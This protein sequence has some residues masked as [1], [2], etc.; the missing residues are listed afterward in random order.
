MSTTI[1]QKV[2]EMRFDNRNFENNVKQSLSTLDRLKQKL[3]LSGASKGLE[4]ISTTANKMNLN[5]MTNAIE[6]VRSKFSVLEVAGITAIANITNS[7]VNAGKRLVKSL[8]I[9]QVAAGWNKYEKKTSS[10]QTLMNSTGKS[11]DE[12][13]EYLDQLMW[14]SDETSYGFTDMTAALAQMTSSGGKIE[15]LIPMIT[16]VANATAYAGKGAAE[17]SRVMYNLN[18]SYGF[19][20]LQLMDWK[21]IELAGAGSKQ[22]KQILIDTAVELGK[23]KEG[24][25]TIASFAT[26]LKDKWADTEV[27]EQAF[28]KFSTLSEAAYKAVASGEYDTASEAIEALSEKYAGVGV[29]AFRSAQ[30][31]KTFR[32]AIDATK[33]AMGSSFMRI[34]ESIF[35]NYV[36]AKELWT[37]LANTLYDVFVEPINSIQSKIE[38][39][40]SFNPFDAL[41]EKI[42]N[43]NVGQIAKKVDNISKSLEYYQDMVNDVWRGDYKNQPY[44]KG[45]LEAEG[46]NYE[47][48]QSLVNKGYQ[49]KLT[50]DDITEAEKKH[51]IEARNTTDALENLSD[52]KLKEIGLT[53]DEIKMYRDLEAQ[54]KKTGKSI[55]ELISE[56]ENK[57][58]RTLL[59]EGFKNLGSSILKI[60]ESIKTAWSDVFPSKSVVQIYNIIAAFNKFSETIKSGVLRN[61][62]NLMRT[63]RGVF[64]ILGFISDIA[65]GAFKIVFAVLKEVLKAFGFGVEN[66]LDFTAVLG[67]A[68]YNARKWVKENSLLAKGIQFVAKYIK[69]AIE[70]TV[71]WVK[72]NDKIQNSI[73]NIKNKLMTFGNAIG[74]W[75]QGLKETDNIPKYIIDGLVNGLKNGVKIAVDAIVNLGKMLLEGIKKVLGIHS[76]STEFFEIGKNIVLGL[77]NGIKSMV[78]IAYEL[79]TTVGEK[80]IDIIKKLDIGSVF[81]IALGTGLIASMLTIS[82]AINAVTSP[83]ESLNGAIQAAKLKFTA[84]LIKSFAIAITVLAAAIG[85]LST[86]DQ[87]KL[88]SAVG[89]IT[90]LM[91]LLSGLVIAIG[92]YGS[93]LDLSA[94]DFGKIALTLLSFGIAI[95]LMA[96]A[97]KN[98][99]SIESGAGKAIVSLIGMI[100]GLVILM[101]AASGNG[102]QTEKAASM[103]IGIGVALWIMARVVKTLGKM[104]TSELEQGTKFILYFSGIIA[105]LMLLSNLMSKTDG[106]GSSILKISVALLILALLA[107]I[108]G[109][110]DPEVLSKGLMFITMFGVLIAALMFITRLASGNST[111]LEKIG[112]AI[113][114]ISLAMVVMAAAVGILGKMNTTTLG[115]GVVSVGL[116]GA[117]IIALMGFTRLASGKE[118]VDKIGT[119]ILKLSFAIGVLAAAVVILGMI[120]GGTLAKGL[121]V[122]SVLSIIVGALTYITKHAQNCMGTLIA[123]T[124]AIAILATAVGVLSLIEPNRLISASVALGLV[125]GMFAVLMKSTSNINKSIPMLMALSAA[126]VILAGALFLIGQLPY[127]RAIGSS[128][129]LSIL[130]LTLTGSLAIISGMGKLS[131]DA[132][133][134]L[135]GMLALV[136]LVYLVVGALAIMGNIQNGAQ[137]AAALGQFMGVLALVLLISAGV[138]AIYMATAGIAATGLL[139]LVVII[140]AVYAVIELLDM[141]NAVPNA[142]ENLEALTSFL[143]LMGDILL[144]LA[145]VGP[146]ALIGVGAMQ[147][148]V[149][150]MVEIGLLATA[151]G[152]LMEKFPALEDF[153]DTGMSVLTQLAEGIGEM[154]GSFVSG[155]LTTISESLPAVAEDLS[156]FMDKLEGFIQGAKKIDKDMING[157][158]YLTEAIVMLTAAKLLDGITSFIMG[159]KNFT[160]FGEEIS[161]F[162]KSLKE[163]NDTTKDIKSDHIIKIAKITD[164]FVNILNDMPLSDG[165]LQ[166]VIGE[167]SLTKLADGLSEL[168]EEYVALSKDSEGIDFDRVTKVLDVSKKITEV[169]NEIPAT[170]GYLQKVMGENSL[171]TLTIGLSKLGKKMKELS[172]NTE[173][174]DIERVTKVLDASKKITE[175]LNEIPATDGLLQRVVGEKSLTTLTDGLKE[176]GTKLKELSDDTDGI[177]IN[178]VESIANVGKKIAQA[179]EEVPPTDGYLQKITGEK[180]LNAITDGLGSLGG[181]LKKL[182]ED[183]EGADTERVTDMVEATKTIAESLN[184]LPDVKGKKLEERIDAFADG[185]DYLGENLAGFFEYIKDTKFDKAEEATKAIKT[186]S[187][188]VANLPD[189]KGK[190]IEE[191]M[192]AFAGNMSLLGKELDGFFYHI[193]DTKFDNATTATDAITKIV[194][195][196]QKIPDMKAKKLTERINT[197]ASGISIIGKEL[198]GFFYHIKETNFDNATVALKTVTDIGNVVKDLPENVVGKCTGLGNGISSLGTQLKAFMDSIKEV[199][200]A[201]AA[202]AVQLIKDIHG[203]IVDICSGGTDINSIS[204][205]AES[206]G[207]LGTKFKAF[208]KKVNKIDYEKLSAAIKSM[209]DTFTELNGL[210]SVDGAVSIIDS[211]SE[212]I[213]KLTEVPTNTT[214]NFVAALKAMGEK[215]KDGLMQGFADLET[216]MADK[217]KAG[218]EKFGKSINNNQSIAT[219]AVKTMS[220][221]CIKS[222]SIG[223]YETLGKNVVQ[224]F[225]RGIS[226]NT[227]LATAKARAMANKAEQAA[228]EA[229]DIHSPSKVFRKIGSR[230]PEGFAQGIGTMNSSIKRA[231]VNMSNSTVDTTKNILSRIIDTIDM[232]FDSQPTIRPVLDLS[233]VESGAGYLSS[234]F[235]D[236]PS[237]GVMANLNAIKTDMNNKLQNDS[238]N[239]VVTAIDKLRKDMSNMNGDTY[240]I[241]GI[242]YDD[243]SNISEAVGTLIRAAIIER[244]T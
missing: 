10:V 228:K 23:I 124:A 76:P 220:N 190:K 128:V 30:E 223:S 43:S 29:A 36:Q 161:E 20:S 184:L 129:A 137:N 72:N 146:L 110:M 147:G 115:K 109:K 121:A 233:E 206:I 62:D 57:D 134:G 70:W 116:L 99:A 50:V 156:E 162:G 18:Q 243:G 60:F 186:I 222:I 100:G 151:I 101:K 227:F 226:A 238:N 54:S 6:T 8:S 88:W 141:M 160:D 219:N 173:G 21:S 200:F 166:T 83:F 52:A 132:F 27:M 61:S 165:Y 104:K 144:M 211:F 9:D 40:M 199:E 210:E 153:L 202:P 96:K 34:F 71:N 221:A 79:L 194:E 42:E 15:K 77:F 22:L 139:G 32:E 231:V 25:V 69:M 4:N 39:V 113:F 145:I 12:I 65:G 126:V 140:G 178:R 55:S 16:G 213:N 212:S 182:S 155:A 73:E 170:D 214:P 80:L 224:G 163:F 195:A 183:T 107:R 164:E 143:E 103:L 188:T 138:G 98:I 180:G 171:T 97:L 131:K 33:D 68:I 91:L 225:A 179:L 56:M 229:L 169:L 84:E 215:G 5:G 112:G 158:I 2:V 53:D 93:K 196:V 24:E 154:L 3:N 46:H 87:L 189:E 85:I 232:D 38:K 234:L 114:K 242:T 185:I 175:L 177:D 11:L 78:N 117:I 120:N 28:G 82:K 176:L 208:A 168:A 240:N 31:A 66:V 193:K 230:I 92:K 209:K 105:G 89:A 13:N 217:A 106:I 197:F 203:A 45:L 216:N 58:G 130:L 41:L 37:D 17:F 19:G 236:G 150:L 136:G 192:K 159:G 67:D 198:D 26:S 244:R 172:D 14:Y 237:V 59:I 187:D 127:E 207:T 135:A 94:L 51:G 118:N 81:T 47:V 111:K 167:K 35:G 205:I 149:L 201:K 49:Y 125:M 142:I 218:L 241:N 122:V 157:I 7:A 108:L 64:S 95:A 90:V 239:N 148:L 102:I 204:T 191:R 1:D 44:R 48:I 235:N 86:L 174:I 75:F 123:I 152:A 133:L 119:T 181:K 63:L 74:K